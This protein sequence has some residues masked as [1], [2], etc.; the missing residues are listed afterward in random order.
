MPLNAKAKLHTSLACLLLT[1]C[2]AVSSADNRGATL[3][4]EFYRTRIEEIFLKQR[5][6]GARCYDCHSVLT[7]RLRL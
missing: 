4:F 2:G 7:T 6:S 5:D 3:D 1:L